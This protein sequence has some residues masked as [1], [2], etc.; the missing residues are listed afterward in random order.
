MYTWDIE[1]RIGNGALVIKTAGVF[2]LI[3]LNGQ[4]RFDGTWL[5]WPIYCDCD[6]KDYL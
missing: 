6:S 1:Q 5:G 3:R 4:P 2:R